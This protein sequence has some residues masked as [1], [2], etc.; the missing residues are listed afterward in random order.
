MYCS[1]IYTAINSNFA[2]YSTIIQYMYGA[3][4]YSK[5]YSIIIVGMTFLGI[6]V[7]YTYSAQGLILRNMQLSYQ[8]DNT[9]GLVLHSGFLRLRIH[10]GNTVGPTCN[11][12]GP[13][14]CCTYK[15]YYKYCTILSIDQV[16]PSRTKTVHTVLLYCMI[17]YYSCC[18]S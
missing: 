5:S 18:G 15:Y 13:P 16:G 9:L 4:E 2:F 1:T 7:V 14:E 12:E 3:L 6:N 8:F 17:Y 10:V 11:V